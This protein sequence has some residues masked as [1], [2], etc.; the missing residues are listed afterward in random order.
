MGASF[1]GPDIG[2]RINKLQKAVEQGRV[3]AVK[4]SAEKGKAAQLAVMR[5][6]SGGDLKL[7]GVGRGARVGVNY[8]VTSSGLSASALMKATGPVQ[9]IDGPTSSHLIRPRRGVGRKAVLN[10]PGVGFRRSARHPGTSG[11]G[12]WT[13]GC[14]LARP[15]IAVEMKKSTTSTIAKGMKG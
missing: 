4:R 9:L 5:S 6:D 8:R 3:D 2:K 11:K 7:S 12:T 14:A 15:V 1:I 10:I 13:R